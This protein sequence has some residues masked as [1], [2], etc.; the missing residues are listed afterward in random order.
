MLPKEDKLHIKYNAIQQDEIASAEYSKSSWS[1]DRKS[2]VARII[3]QNQCMY[4]KVSR[5]KHVHCLF[6]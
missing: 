4:E 5:S 2:R 3:Q 6:L 1:T